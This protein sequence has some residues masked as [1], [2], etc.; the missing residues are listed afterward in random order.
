[1]PKSLWLGGAWR[2]AALAL[3]A[4][5]LLG[6]AYRITRPVIEDRQNQQMQIDLQGAVPGARYQEVEETLLTQ[7]AQGNTN[8]AIV[9]KLFWA[10]DAAEARIGSVAF[11]TGQGYGG[12]LDVVVGLDSAGRVLHVSVGTNHETPGIGS[13]ATVADYLS[14]YLSA[15]ADNPPVDALSG[16][17]ISSRAIRECVQAAGLVDAACTAESTQEQS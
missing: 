2:L 17:T 16:A 6:A 1:M 14:G 3:V 5:L 9:Q 8:H 12:D 13:R 11:V 4:G 7:A 10:Y 15:P